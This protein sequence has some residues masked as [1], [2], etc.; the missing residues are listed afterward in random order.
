MSSLVGRC[1]RNT[2]NS[3]LSFQTGLR[4]LCP[5]QSYGQKLPC[6]APAVVAEILR[7]STPSR[8]SREELC[9]EPIQDLESRVWF[10]S[11]SCPA[12]VWFVS[13]SCLVRVRFVPGSCPVR[14]CSVSGSC[15]VRIWFRSAS[16][17][18][19]VRFVSGFVSG[20]RL[21]SCPVRVWFVS[22]FASGTRLGSCPVLVQFVVRVW[23]VPGSCLVSVW[24]VSCSCLVRVWVRV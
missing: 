2:V 23:F 4:N 24:F 21:G 16:C 10:V 17:P 20:S 19:R 18:V 14:V 5:K 12:S 15:P 8:G 6:R 13:G 9:P 11:G 7:R 3:L 22:G 1:R